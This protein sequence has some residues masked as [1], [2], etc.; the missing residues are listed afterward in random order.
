MM[1]EQVVLATGM[2]VEGLAQVLHGHGRALDMPARIP[3][4]PGRIP[5]LQIARLRGPPE[6][7]VGGM[8]LVL[9]HLDTRARDAIVGGLRVEP[10]AVSRKGGDVEV[11]AV[12]GDVRVA[13]LDE[14]LDEVDHRSD[15]LGRLR[16]HVGVEDVEP[17][18]VGD[19]LSGVELGDLKRILPR[20]P[21]AQR[22]LVL[23]RVRV[24]DDVTDVR[25]VHDLHHP[26]AEVFER[27][28]HHVRDE[29]GVEIPDV[30]PVVYGRTAVVDADRAGSHR[31]ERARRTR[32]AV[33]DVDL[34]FGSLDEFF[35]LVLLGR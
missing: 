13:L 34:G 15:V 21:R 4:A 2:H 20:A 3:P 30:L 24:V 18:T 12:G 19:E 31:L 1:R 7:K 35:S 16:H 27:P 28:P 33:V 10:R 23:A 22:H 5:L 14:P 6:R 8:P 26:V 25:D 29:V 17:P 11:H 32:R 9:V